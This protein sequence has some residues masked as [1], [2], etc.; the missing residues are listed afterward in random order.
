MPDVAP[1]TAADLIAFERS[2][3]GRG[4]YVNGTSGK[5]IHGSDRLEFDCIGFQKWCLRQKQLYNSLFSQVEDPTTVYE[6]CKMFK[7]KMDTAK[8]QYGDLVVFGDPRSGDYH[9]RYAHIG[10]VTNPPYTPTRPLVPGHYIS[11]FD[12]KLEIV[13]RKFE[14][15]RT[16]S[17]ITYLHLGLK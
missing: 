5:P 3:I 17:L 16:M 7:G 9:K 4:K 1:I 8:P 11:M 13:E 14:T 12:P 6:F 15:T 10:C 2:K